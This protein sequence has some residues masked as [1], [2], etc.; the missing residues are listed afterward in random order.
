[1]RLAYHHLG[2]D[3]VSIKRIVRQVQKQIR[4]TTL[5]STMEWTL[6]GH[7]MG[8]FAAMRLFFHIHQTMPHQHQHRHARN[9]ATRTTN[10][11]LFG[12]KLV[13]W[14]I[15]PFLPFVTDL[16]SFANKDA[17]VLV[18]QGSED[19]LLKLL[20]SGQESLES[21]F[22]KNT[23]TEVIV[24]GTH[25]GFAHY[26]VPST[27]TS[28]QSVITDTNKRVVMSSVLRPQDQ[29]EEACA[30]TAQFIFAE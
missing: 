15:T 23:R 26:I 7:S 19:Q 12:T 27:T 6:M 30:M 1:M 9:T 24:G 29:Q 28:H 2:A 20:Q 13:L 17:K 8:C 5:N 21:S 18:L 16:S 4:L 14:G 25:D 11:L 10:D 3:A 22:P